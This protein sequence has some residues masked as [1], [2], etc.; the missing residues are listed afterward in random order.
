MEALTAL[1]GKGDAEP[2]YRDI[3]LREALELAADIPLQIAEA[4]CD[5]ATLAALLVENG[6]PEVRADAA[7]AAVLAEGGTRAAAKLVAV[8]LA[9]S[10][11]DDRRVRQAQ[12]L[13]KRAAEATQRA[14]AA[15][16]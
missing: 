14:L 2:R 16:E 5:L 12:A 11:D 4:G 10:D 1:R 8:N 13:V 6:N 15:A 9:A 7:V 3:K